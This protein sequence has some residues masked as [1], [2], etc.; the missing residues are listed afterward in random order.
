MTSTT[1]ETSTGFPSFWHPSSLPQAEPDS[2]FI[3]LWWWRLGCVPAWC[4]VRGWP[5]E[6]SVFSH[7]NTGLVLRFW[8]RE[9]WFY[10][11]NL[12]HFRTNKQIYKWIREGEALSNSESI[13]WG[14]KCMWTERETSLSIFKGVTRRHRPCYCSGPAQVCH[15]WFKLRG[16]M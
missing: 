4:G 3:S 16:N 1:R 11:C 6:L 15:C 9:L 2:C 7:L 14:K 12:I 5:Q 13:W 8:V 10:H